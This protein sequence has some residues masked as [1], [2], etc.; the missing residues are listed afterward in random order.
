MT[1]IK[2]FTL[3]LTQLACIASAGTVT[4][5]SSAP[6][7]N[8]ISSSVTGGTDTALFDEDANAN[9]SRG[10]LFSLPDGSGTNYQITS[11]TVKKSTDQAYVNDTLT[12]HLFEGAQAQWDSGTGHSTAADGSDYYVDTT[13]TPLHSETFN[14]NG[15]ITNNHYVTFELTAPITVSEDSDFGFFMTYDRSAPSNPD[16]FR[17]RENGSGGGRISITTSNHGT[18]G[19]GSRKVVY[20]VQGTTTSVSGVVTTSVSAPTTDILATKNLGATGSQLFSIGA[21]ANHVRGQLFP[22]GESAGTTFVV[23]AIT[24]QKNTAQTFINDT[25]TLRLFEG[26]QAQWDSGTGRISSN[27]DFHTGT[28]VTPLRTETFTL[29]GTIAAQE[30][31]TFE[32][33][34]P[35][36][37]SE[38]SDFGF[39]LAYEPVGGA[40]ISFT[41]LEATN[42]GRLSVDADSHDTSTRSLNHFVQGTAIIPPDVLTFAAPFQSGMILQRDKAIKIWGTANP[43]TAVSVSIDGIMTSGTS[44]PDGKWSVEL[45]ALSSGGPHTLTATAGSAAKTLSDVLIG[46]V[47]LAF[48]QSNMVQILNNMTDKQF[49]IDEIETNNVPVRCLKVTQFGALTQQEAATV[50]A[51][52]YVNGA[53]NW[54]APSTSETWTSVGTVFAYRMYEATGVPTAI[55]WAAWGSSSIEGWMPSELATQLPHYEELLPDYNQVGQAGMVSARATNAGYSTNTAYLNDLFTSGWTGGSSNPDIF[56]RTRSNVIYNQM[57]HPLRNFGISGFLWYQGEANAGNITNAAEYGF[58]LPLLIKEYRKRFGQGELPFLGVQLPSHNKSAWPWFR[59]SQNRM[60]TLPNAYAAITIDTGLSGNIHPPDKESIGIRLALLARKYQQGEAIEAHGP[61]FF[62]LALAGNQATVTFTNAVGLITDDAL[63]PATFEVAGSDEIFHAATNTSISGNDVIISSSS[64][65]NPVAVRYAWSPTPVN[66][67]N[68]V[69]SD[70]L[71]AAPFR[72]DSFA[73]PGLGAQAPQSINDSYQ[74]AR[75]QTLNASGI[76]EN[77]ID[78]NRDTLTATLITDVNFGTLSLLSDGSFTYTPDTG[79]AGADSFTYQCSDGE[80]TSATA[81][82]SIAVS[83]QNTNYYVWKSSITW[84][85]ND[86]SMTADP[87]GDGTSNFLEFAFGL[88]PLVASSAGLPTLTPS[89]ADTAYNFNNVQ[90]GLTYEVRLSTDLENWREPAFATITSADITPVIIP[91]N[92]AVDGNLFVRL[93]VSE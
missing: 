5:S 1:F 28:T 87:D 71:P 61:R 16:R 23:N 27:P 14:L 49:Y 70:G 42:G 30:F 68:L 46:D 24:I 12:L 29:N 32:L 43:S 81:T 38:N 17:H 4:I 60:E 39:F 11:I 73:L 83:G 64:E 9:H 90:P 78:L 35:L 34:T 85:A 51:G 57:I 93:R 33:A 76:L 15:T 72:T 40:A 82:V 53:M 36:I 77:D 59:E 63:S 69:N 48:G 41:L 19:T 89:G 84:G 56:V 37:L 20:F 25:I 18:T 8:L 10:Q 26:T 58:S 3:L 54:L 6:T 47:W 79:Y 74:V 66:L 67:V 91:F 45:P 92:L 22:L 31:V 21:N 62:S 86:D 55:I 13:V 75:D 65:P 2:Y 50:P 80:L 52:H 7:T 44:G 88:D